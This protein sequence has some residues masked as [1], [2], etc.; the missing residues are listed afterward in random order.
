MV[1]CVMVKWPILYIYKYFTIL[2]YKYTYGRPTV[3]ADINGLS[4][5]D[6]PVNTPTTMRAYFKIPGDI[7]VGIKKEVSSLF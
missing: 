5:L 2:S 4:D 6:K 1:I 3:T 7:E